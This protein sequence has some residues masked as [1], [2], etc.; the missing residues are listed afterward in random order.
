[1]PRRVDEPITVTLSP[2][3]E[4]RSFVWRRFQYEV[5]GTP[6]TFFRRLPWWRT[7]GSLTRI[8]EE[9]WRVEATLTG[10]AESARIYELARAGEKGW[11]LFAEWE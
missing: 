4:P 11:T 1:M 7:R 10:A 2:E 3:G 8:D 9:F 5:I 6:L